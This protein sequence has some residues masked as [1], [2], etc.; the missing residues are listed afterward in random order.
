MGCGRVGQTIARLLNVSGACEVQDIMT[1]GRSR[2]EEAIAFIQAGRPVP[3][4]AAM[5]PAGICMLTVPDRL[6]GDVAAELSAALA[7]TSTAPGPSPIDVHCSGFT[8][9]AVLA[10]LRERGFH[11][12]SVHPNL[13][14]ADPSAAV[15]RFN[16]APCGLEG[17]EAAL[18]ELRPLF[19]ATGGTGFPVRAGR[20]ALDHAAAVLSN[21]FTVVLHAIAAEAWTAAG[22]PAPVAARI[23]ASLF[24]A[25]V[26]NVLQFWAGALTGPAAR[27]DMKVV[28]TQGTAV[29]E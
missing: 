14:F 9:A 25:T 17:D 29:F 11:V 10:P 7:L 19:E 13:T 26:T 6:I 2:V 4:M 5:R 16:G 18:A 21:S 12:A 24:E 20:K 23:Q 15:T 27:G 1:G 28:R 3:S 22:V 8:P